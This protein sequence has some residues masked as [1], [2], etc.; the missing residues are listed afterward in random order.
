MLTRGDKKHE[1]R[2]GRSDSHMPYL[3]IHNA[4]ERNTEIPIKKK[5]ADTAT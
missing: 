4:H 5:S 1:Y 2:R 3:D